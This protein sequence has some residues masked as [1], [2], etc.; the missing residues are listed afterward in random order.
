MLM[1]NG[2]LSSGMI[3]IALLRN[4]GS[5]TD[6]TGGQIYMAPIFTERSA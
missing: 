3:A 2:A 4:V 6:D 5:A 1:V